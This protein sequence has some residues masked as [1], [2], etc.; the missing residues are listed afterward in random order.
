MM[1][2]A[3]SLQGRAVYPA[4]SLIEDADA[5][6]LWVAALGDA[7]S[8]V[9]YA[10]FVRSALG[11]ELRRALIDEPADPMLPK[12]LRYF[13]N[14]PAGVRK[15]F[16]VGGCACVRVNVHL[17]VCVLACARACVCV[18]VCVCVRELCVSVCVS[19]H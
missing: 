4:C 13:L 6:K 12:M 8:A 7:R 18:C 11:P 14:F 5:R 1:V 2:I 15:C 10:E 19:V 3:G 17:C 16:C 9:A